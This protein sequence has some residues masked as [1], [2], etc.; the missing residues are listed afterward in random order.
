MVLFMT[1]F[2]YVK[3]HFENETLLSLPA[4]LPSTEMRT[5]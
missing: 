5:G 2:K 3:V 1:T 4:V